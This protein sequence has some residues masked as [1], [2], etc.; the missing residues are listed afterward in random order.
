MET[1][2][3]L[4]DIQCMHG[5]RR[6]RLTAVTVGHSEDIS[7]EDEQAIVGREHGRFCCGRICCRPA[8][9]G[10]LIGKGVKRFFVGARFV[11]ARVWHVDGGGGNI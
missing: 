6:G 3:R 7:R 1:K 8:G 10:T 4:D 11:R 9:E 2:L 5:V